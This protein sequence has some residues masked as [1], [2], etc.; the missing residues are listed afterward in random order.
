MVKWD[1]KATKAFR[2]LQEALCCNP[3]LV[4]P[5]FERQFVVQTDASEIGLGAVLSQEVEGVE[6][7]ILF[8]SRKLEPWENNYPVIEKEVLAVVGCRK[9]EILPDRAPL[10]PHQ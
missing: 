7:P 2:T 10:H 6:H 8:L 4:V 3:V 1:E 5:D 9:P